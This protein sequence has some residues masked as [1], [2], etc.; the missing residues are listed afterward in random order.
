MRK[1]CCKTM[2]Q[3]IVPESCTCLSSQVGNTWACEC[4]GSVI[5]LE[6]DGTL[7]LL[8]PQGIKYFC[9]YCPWCG[10]PHG[11]SIANNII[12]E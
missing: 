1:Y 8:A 9:F 7:T 11:D 5:K 6:E 12:E 3:S 4:Y 2:E 10:T